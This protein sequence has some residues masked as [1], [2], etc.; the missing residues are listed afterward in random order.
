MDNKK[1]SPQAIQI[2]SEKFQLANNIALKSTLIKFH[3]SEVM[4]G[5]VDFVG[6]LSLPIEAGIISTLSRDIY[7]KEEHDV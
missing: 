5:G 1:Y 2:T 4:P 6:E 3:A 7:R